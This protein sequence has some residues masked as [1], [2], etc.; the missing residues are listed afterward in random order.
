M[1]LHRALGRGLQRQVQRGLDDEIL[2]RLADQERTW[3]STQSVKYW[4]RWLARVAD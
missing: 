1:R 3:S 4:A 2:G